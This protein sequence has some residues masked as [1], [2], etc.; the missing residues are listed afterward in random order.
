MLE[1]DMLQVVMCLHAVALQTLAQRPA[2]LAQVPVQK[3]LL[4]MRLC[5]YG[6]YLSYFLN[7]GV[8]TIGT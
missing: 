5:Q 7:G 4:M 2:D 8:H 6:T 1:H 3:L